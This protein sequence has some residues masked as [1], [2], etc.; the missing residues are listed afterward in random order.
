MEILIKLDTEKNSQT[1][2]NAHL[3]GDKLAFTIHE[4]QELIFKHE[5]LSENFKMEFF[6]IINENLGNIEDYTE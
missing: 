6:H 5:D 1:K 3:Q 2:I 4:L